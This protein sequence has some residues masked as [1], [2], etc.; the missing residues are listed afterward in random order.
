MTKPQKLY[1]ARLLAGKNPTA[2]AHNTYLAWTTREVLRLDGY[3]DE[4]GQLTEAGRRK[5]E[6]ME[7]EGAKC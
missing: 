4:H 2:I 5:A 6:K 1:L 7:R 3:L